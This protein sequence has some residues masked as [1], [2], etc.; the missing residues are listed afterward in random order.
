MNSSKIIG[1]AATVIAL[2]SLLLSV[3]QG[4]ETRRHD[5]LMVRPSLVLINHF[6][7]GDPE[8]GVLLSNKG[9][10]PAF[11]RELR[12][13]VDG[14]RVA[15]DEEGGWK[16]ARS[17][18]GISAPWI[19]Y[20]SGAVISASETMPLIAIKRQNQNDERKLRL[21][22]AVARLKIEVDYES[23]YGEEFTEPPSQGRR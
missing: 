20:S 10:G 4:S 16:H 23:A 18:L 13:F 19:H 9:I 5:R 7:D 8:Y 14:K 1:I 21:R 17:Q 2:A 6:V 15:K 3:W 12:I 22:E 11:V